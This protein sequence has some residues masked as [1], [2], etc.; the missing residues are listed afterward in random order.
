MASVILCSELGESSSHLVMLAD[1]AV[2][3]KAQGYKVHVVG[4]DLAVAHQIP[5]F[6]DI[7]LFQTPA[8][9]SAKQQGDGPPFDNLNYSS[10]LRNNGYH[11]VATLAPLLRGWMNLVSALQADLIV[12][13]H[14]PTALLTAR[15]L[16]IPCI[17]TGAGYAVPPLT[18][19]M[20]CITPWREVTDEELLLEDQMLLQVVN[21]TY[22]ELNFPRVRMHTAKELISHAAQWIVSIPE[23]DHYGARNQPYV[24]RRYDSSR[25]LAADWPMGP[26]DRI[27][28]HLN[29]DSPYLS[30][31]L[32]QLTANNAP[33]LVIVPGAS[34]GLVEMYKGTN[35]KVQRESVSI[36]Q[37]V[38]QCKV[39]IN[40][41]NH[42]LVY[43]LLSYGVPSIFLPSEPENK[44]LAYRLVKLRV[45]FTGPASPAELDLER[46]IRANNEQD[47][48]WHNAAGVSIKYEDREKLL[49]LHSVIKAELVVP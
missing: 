32:E 24:A 30:P 16:K 18:T 37:A 41:A 1:Y 25:R 10:V 17:M 14:A 4:Q 23:M 19:P 36:R 46:M 9:G 20:S 44:L 38:D 39:F 3:L 42:D 34:N 49:R 35:I 31:L 45:G 8:I 29:A 28:V 11:D 48:V 47:Q 6:S 7:P 27:L 2:E 12:A 43:E 15:L 26:G 13:H 40:E 5:E 33:T 22:A 21:D